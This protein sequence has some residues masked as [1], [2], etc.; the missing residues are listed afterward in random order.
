MFKRIKSVSG[1]GGFTLLE[2]VAVLIIIG[3]L[4]SFAVANYLSLSED[5]TIKGM[6]ELVSQLNGK[7]R[8]AWGKAKLDETDTGAINNDSFAL[9]CNGV[10]GTIDDFDDEGYT[11]VSQ[12]T[13]PDAGSPT[14]VR[15]H[16]YEMSILR[17]SATADTPASWAITVAPAPY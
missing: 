5:A 15:W 13:I 6:E 12:G 17:T 16:G 7:E 1:N 9:V 8:M 4:A 2:L 14:A 11:F 10:P 3:I